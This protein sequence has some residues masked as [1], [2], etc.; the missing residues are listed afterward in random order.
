MLIQTDTVYIYIP[1]N[2]NSDHTRVQRHL[3]R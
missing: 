2:K 1:G 3:Q